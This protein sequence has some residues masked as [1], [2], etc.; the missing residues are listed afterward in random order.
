MAI[1]IV[2]AAPEVTGGVD[3]HSEMHVAAALDPLG[4]LVGT[5]SFDANLGYLPRRRAGAGSSSVIVAMTTSYSRC[6]ASGGMVNLRSSVGRVM[7]ESQ[8]QRSGRS[9]SR[10][11]PVGFVAQGI[12]GSQAVHQLLLWPGGPVLAR[13]SPA[14][15]TLLQSEQRSSILMGPPQSAW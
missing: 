5:E 14:R 3:T 10:S 15:T 6:P 4:R 11:W 1:T 9:A 8:S 7:I 2:E 12:P 13:T